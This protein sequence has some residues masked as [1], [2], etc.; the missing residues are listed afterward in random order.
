MQKVCTCKELTPLCCTEGWVLTYAGSRFT[1]PAESR[2]HPIEGEALGVAWGLHKTRHFTLGCK[3]LVVAVDHKPLLKIFGDR[4]LSEIQNPRILNFKE[5]T[6]KWRFQVKHI[7][8]ILHKIADAASRS[9]VGE[10]TEEL[11]TDKSTEDN[12]KSSCRGQPGEELDTSRVELRVQ[13]TAHAQLAALGGHVAGAESH[14]SPRSI[15][16][17]TL[18]LESGADP[19]LQ[20]LHKLVTEGP[21]EEKENWPILLRGY[22]ANQR[23]CLQ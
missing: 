16:W 15:P 13:A 18:C 6:L 17:S 23:I 14:P 11:K 8:G 12:M 3:N 4:E 10:A 20:D 2:Y 1:S 19:L 5:K 7:P 9:P 21:P 22:Y